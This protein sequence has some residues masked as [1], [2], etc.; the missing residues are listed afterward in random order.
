MFLSMFFLPGSLLRE[1][2]FVNVYS[3]EL[4]QWSHQTGGAGAK[5]IADPSHVFCDLLDGTSGKEEQSHKL[6]EEEIFLGGGATHYSPTQR[7]FLRFAIAMPISD[8]KT[9]NRF[10]R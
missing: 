5:H 9:C 6:N 2:C 3:L 10:Q 8:A 1:S 7:R 4:A